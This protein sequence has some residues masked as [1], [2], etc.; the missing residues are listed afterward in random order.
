MEKFSR[1]LE[2]SGQRLTR[3]IAFAFLALFLLV[4]GA[5][6][7]GLW[8]Q[9]TLLTALHQLLDERAKTI[10]LATELQSE[11][12]RRQEILLAQ[13][14]SKDA[15][16]REALYG[17]YL[18]AS[19]RVDS[20]RSRLDQAGKDTFTRD[21][22]ARLNA[23]M[24]RKDELSEQA[25]VLNNRGA[26]DS[27]LHLLQDQTRDLQQNVADI[28]QGLRRHQQDLMDAQAAQTQ[29]DAAHNRRIALALS[30]VVC[31]LI[32]AVYLAVRKLL[33]QRAKAVT[34]KAREIET[35][36]ERLF[37]EATQDALTGLANRRMFF[38]QLEQA[39]ASGQRRAGG[40]ALAYVDLDKFKQINDTLGHSAGD[41]L[42]KAVAQRMKSALRESD[43]LARL[44]G[45][46]FAMVLEQASA[47]TLVAL[48][49]KLRDTV[50]Q[51]VLINGKSVVP[52]F[53]IG[54]ALYP[55]HADSVQGLIQHADDVMYEQKARR[56]S[57]IQPDWEPST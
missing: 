57:A 19:D 48:E 12:Y 34:E 9:Q 26:R 17:E 49:R 14:L 7:H 25:L 37:E 24:A 40:L 54:F 15:T 30:G 52:E 36:S 21:S 56:K 20:L 3:H 10:A 22:M 47:E 44:G 28:L 39:V 8:Q 33:L 41:T 38:Q 43:M 45:D 35:L 51:P 55:E 23:I 1:L 50:G 16:E 31:V 13:M 46:E 53:S 27:A 18:A 42:L 11:S 4:L 29:A 5:L 32:G 6:A 2:L